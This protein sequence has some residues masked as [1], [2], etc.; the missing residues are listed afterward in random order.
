MNGKRDRV[1]HPFLFALYPILL[2]YSGNVSELSVVDIIR[3]AAI[4]LAGAALLYFLWKLVLKDSYRAGILTALAVIMFFTYV[5]IYDLFVQAVAIGGLGIGRHRV[6]LPLWCLIYLALVIWIARSRRGG[7]IV[8]RLAN[9]LSLA[10]V[11]ASVVGIAYAEVL[12]VTKPNA[13]SSVSMAQRVVDKMSVHAEPPL[14]DVYYIILDGYGRD[15]ILKDYYGYD[16]SEFVDFLTSKGFYVARESQSNYLQTYLS[17]SSSLNFEYLDTLAKSKDD[18]D[19]SFLGNC[20]A[21]NRICLLM[22]KAGYKFVFFPSGYQTTCRNP[23]ADVYMG[24]S[25]LSMTEFERAL[26]KNSMLYAYNWSA[27]SH[28]SRIR[29]TFDDLKRV[30]EDDAPTFAFAHIVCPHPPYVFDANGKVPHIP[31]LVKAGLLKAGTSTQQLCDLYVGQVAYINKQVLET[32]DT[33][34]ARSK[35]PPIIIL[36]ADHGPNYRW[37]NT[38]MAEGSVTEADTAHAGDRPIPITCI[39]NAYYFPGDG[40]DQLYDS[41][42]PVNSFRVMLNRYFGTTLPILEDRTYNTEWQPVHGGVKQF[43][44]LPS[45]HSPKAAAP[46]KHPSP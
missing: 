16:N 22:K 14:R 31:Y 34:L 24:A 35:V 38:G 41:I 5:R 1:L 19:Y 12:H 46:A 17:L 42:T 20:I 44:R 45:W 3:P 15:D 6:F 7:Q 23:H 4:D 8:T 39:L 13:G 40:P 26:I 10:L 43:I 21:D 2:L 9:Y 18:L 27:S 29:R 11:L 30:S 36:Q 33:V 37:A 32:I 28:R 25:G